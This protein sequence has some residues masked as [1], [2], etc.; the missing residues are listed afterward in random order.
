MADYNELFEQSNMWDKTIT[1]DWACNYPNKVEELLARI[2]EVVDMQKAAKTIRYT[3]RYNEYLIMSEG[4]VNVLLYYPIA[5]G[6]VKNR[7]GYLPKKFTSFIIHVDQITE[8]DLDSLSK[9]PERT[10]IMLMDHYEP[11]AVI[12]NRIEALKERFILNYIQLNR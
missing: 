9:L 8:N 10:S 6:A 2:D 12:S 11:S 7:L 5:F 1:I 3:D 4:I